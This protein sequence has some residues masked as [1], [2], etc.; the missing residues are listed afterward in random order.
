MYA[1]HAAATELFEGKNLTGNLARWYLSIQEFS[2]KFK[3]RQGHPNVVAD[4]LSRNPLVWVVSDT[5]HVTN[6]SLLDLRI[7]QRKHD[8][9]A[10]ALEP[11][12]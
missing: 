6:F 10:E 12:D 3:Y 2:P 7:A 8:I 5:P 9:W 4:V 11:E 1:A